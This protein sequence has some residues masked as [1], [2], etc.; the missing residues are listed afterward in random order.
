VERLQVQVEPLHQLV[1]D[2]LQLL[3]LGRDVGLPV[4]QIGEAI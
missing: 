1:Q 4:D 2:V 3:Q